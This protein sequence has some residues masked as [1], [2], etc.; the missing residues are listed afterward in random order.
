M[1]ST[2]MASAPSLALAGHASRLTR[3]SRE[4]VA[5]RRSAASTWRVSA[6]RA[7]NAT[8]GLDV[9]DDEGEDDEEDARREPTPEELDAEA[10]VLLQ[11]PELSAQ[12]RAFTATTLGY[13]ACDPALPLGADFEASRRLLA[14][15]TAA[16]ALKRAG[17][18]QREAFE[19]TRDIRPWVLG[20]RRGRVLSGGSL[21]DIAT[22]SAA[23]G[24]VRAELGAAPR[25][26]NGDAGDA[27]D[28]L[29]A[30]T[31][32]SLRDLAEPLESIPATLEPEIRRCV[33]VP[34]GTVRDD[35]SDTLRE[36]REARRETE[37][38]LRALLLEKA[39]FL[40]RKN[41]AERA[42]VVSRLG[43]ECIPMK[44]GAQSEMDG[45]VLGAS[46]T[47]AT[48]FKEPAEAT[49]LNNRLMELA[50]EEEAE[51]ERVLR[52]L[53]EQV[54]G[55][56]RGEALLRATQALAD[57]D[58]AAARAEH[59][60]WLSAKA[61]RL[62]RVGNETSG[63]AAAG[64]EARDSAALRLPGM[65]HPLLLQPRLPALPRGGK[66]GEDE[67]VD[68]WESGDDSEK[69]Q[70]ASED[71]ALEVTTPRVRT[72]AEATDVVPVDFCPPPDTRLVAITGPNTGGKTASL[73]A[74]GLALLMARA[75]LHL[76]TD[77]RETAAVPWTSR[78]LAD[79][80]DAQ[81]L[82]LD[83]GLSTFSAH[84]TR[85]R[86]IL[87][88]ARDTRDAVVVLL[89]EPGGGTD[90]AE[91]AA[92]AAA[93]LRASAERST[94]TVATSHYEEVKALAGGVKRDLLAPVG[95]ENEG[96]AP[97]P[98]PGAANAA[99]EFDTATLRPTYRLLWG[100]SGESNALAVARGLG[101][102][103]ALAE[104]A[105]RRWRRGRAADGADPDA[106]EDLAELASALER[107]RGVQEVRAA[108]ALE[109][110]DRARDLHADVTR[111][112][113]ARLP[114][115]ASLAV[116]AAAARGV[117]GAAEAQSVLAAAATREAID[118]AADALMPD[119]WVLDAATGDAVPGRR[120]RRRRNPEDARSRDDDG[121]S[122]DSFDSI[123]E[124]AWVPRVG[125]T[126]TVRRMGGAE[127][128]VVDV[129]E[130][131]GEVVVR[132]GSITSRAPLAGVSPV[133]GKY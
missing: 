100:T 61:P 118:A 37:T 72:R 112:G 15:T 1:A 18:L 6:A 130:L 117:A 102:E 30:E 124:P 55:A 88:A 36:I 59:A 8:M 2:A 39:A 56:D 35:A 96:E 40:A 73:K 63:N 113:A 50:A 4:R 25:T 119:G 81:S 34:G 17:R 115:R 57:L 110:L 108:R 60:D 62:F 41:F 105:E 52:A 90:P 131:A 3:P 20:A 127:A 125:S 70:E 77:A 23:A 132:M 104:A 43:R 71:E 87:A 11:W 51:T 29:A 42:Q 10:R 86:R 120:R 93:V 74:L 69:A 79:L 48:V 7:S 12:V 94:L 126:V 114:L 101:L 19:G 78:V 46:G 129:D 76:P 44:A 32:E 66:V 121:V 21:A 45:V 33:A 133:V 64:N 83:G 14:E 54:L 31:L 65:Q 67:E 53:T 97:P 16:A 47:G 128:E 85:L 116:D 106:G 92:L 80:G 122:F 75:G 38:G 68:G 9:R 22:T 95:G 111:R 58:L 89:D 109:A 98:F 107:E 103:E 82:D 91:G 5:F 123:D 49:P 26:E 84:L 13:R 28:A 24:T 99:V 27:G